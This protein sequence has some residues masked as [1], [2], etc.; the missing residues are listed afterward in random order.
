MDAVEV[1]ALESITVPKEKKSL[2]H[3]SPNYDTR[4]HVSTMKK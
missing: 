4:K 3:I 1:E 2:I